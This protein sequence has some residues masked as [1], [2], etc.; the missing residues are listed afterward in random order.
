MP[1]GSMVIGSA[2]TTTG[3][4][5]ED[6]GSEDQGPEPNG[7]RAIGPNHITG[8]NGKRAIGGDKAAKQLQE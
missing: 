2:G 1:C 6:A 7:C 5:L 3:L 8:G 4:G